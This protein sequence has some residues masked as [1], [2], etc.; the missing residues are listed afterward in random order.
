VDWTLFWEQHSETVWATLAAVFV[1]WFFGWFYYWRAE[2]PKRFS[3]K[4]VSATPIINS[5]KSDRENLKVLYRGTE[6]DN[7]KM[8]ILRFAN[9]GRKTITKDDFDDRV[10]NTITFGAAKLLSAQVVDK[11]DDSVVVTVGVDRTRPNMLFFEPPFLKRGKF[12][13]V[14]VVTD[15]PLYTPEVSTPFDGSMVRLNRD[16]ADRF[17]NAGSFVFPAFFL[18]MSIF[19]GFVAAG[20]FFLNG[21]LVPDEVALLVVS[22]ALTLAAFWRFQIQVSR[23]KSENQLP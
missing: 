16:E 2:R 11:A 21:E 5:T 20:D 13:D 17:A 8:I 12:F 22:V 18:L 4:I 14:Q 9:G 23:R 15:G 7:P 19:T 6:V 10:Q 3:W 1:T